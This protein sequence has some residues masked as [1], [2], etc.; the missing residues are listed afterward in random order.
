MTRSI[1]NRIMITVSVKLLSGTIDC[2]TSLTLSLVFIHI[3]SE[4]K[5]TLALLVCLGLKL[6]HLTSRNTTQLKNQMSGCCGLSGI[7]VP[8]T[9]NEMCFLP[10]HS[11]LKYIFQ[12]TTMFMQSIF[13][14]VCKIIFLDFSKVAFLIQTLLRI[15]TFGHF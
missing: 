13:I 4:C 6:L 7:D 2:D 11:Y 12:I 5:R 9:T 3:I 1:Y 10:S 15:F 14:F 8:T